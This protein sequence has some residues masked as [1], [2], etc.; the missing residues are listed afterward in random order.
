MASIGRADRA[1][2]RARAAALLRQGELVAFPTET[3][4]GLGAD[5]TNGR[6]VAAI[7]AAKQRPA[8]NP[9]IAHLA[10]VGAVEA[11]AL[12]NDAARAL[13][14]AFWPGAL[15]LVLPRRNDCAIAPI[16]SAGLDSVA[17]RVP[18]H[19]DAHALLAAVQRPVAAPSANRSG[20]IS[21]TTA[22]H[23]EQE[24]GDKVALILDGG[25]CEIGLESTVVG[26]PSGRPVL[27]RPG[28]IS[29]E[30]LQAVAGAVVVGSD[31]ADSPSAPGQ[32]ASHYAPGK[33]LRLNATAAG[34]DEVLLG[35]GPNFA[36]AHNLSPKGDLIEAAANLF[37]LLRQLDQ[38]PGAAIAVAPIPEDGLGRAINDRLRRAAAPRPC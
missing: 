14:E 38:E 35:F 9:L 29:M 24:L 11:F 5:A 8:F 30:Q 16:A 4:Y 18:S 25:P 15:T 23:V 37:A 27:L 31:S 1:E 3:V 7:F 32:L 17:L 19:P 6:A 13:A 12:W 26:F 20:R 34:S 36:A 22:A 28:G 33:G 21:P 2:D 10:D